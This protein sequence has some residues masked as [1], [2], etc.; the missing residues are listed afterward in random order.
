MRVPSGVTG[1]PGGGVRLRSGSGG[2]GE[3]FSCG[4]EEKGKGVG[5]PRGGVG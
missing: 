5:T 4:N 1:V 2:G 3:W